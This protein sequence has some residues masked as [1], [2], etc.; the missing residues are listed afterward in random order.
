MFPEERQEYIL[1]KLK[2]EG[3]VKSDDLS[4][5]LSVSVMTIYRDLDKLEKKGLVKRKYGGAIRNLDLLEEMTIEE[6]SGINIEAK[7]KIAK[8]AVKLVSDGDVL[9]LDAGSTNYQLG[10]LIVQENFTNLTII[11]NDL[12]ISM[13]L[14][15]HEHIKVILVGGAVNS[16]G[17]LTSGY[18]ALEF[19]KQFRI[20]K[21]FIGIQGVSDSF[22]VTTSQESKI[23]YKQYLIENSGQSILLVDE[24]KFGESRMYYI[25]DLSDFDIV[26]TNNTKENLLKYC[27]DYGIN[28]LN[29]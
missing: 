22:H 17:I 18:L 27:S 21:S 19:L 25:C 7:E 23:G 12:K 6:K 15:N 28:L 4:E 13:L 9:F 3:S 10:K 8:S 26:I 1:D 20:N 29:V 16:R 14:L 5:K 11:T 24:S 2:K